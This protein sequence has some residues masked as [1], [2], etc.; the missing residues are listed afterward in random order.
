M[1]RQAEARRSVAMTLA[2]VSL[3]TP[4]TIAVLPSTSISAPRRLQFLH[5]HHAIFEDRLGDHRRAVGDGHQRHQLRLHVGGKGGI[6]RRAQRH[7][8]ELAAARNADHVACPRRSWRRPRR[9]LSSTAP[10]VSG[11]VPRNTTLPPVAMARAPGTCRFRCG[12]ASPRGWRRAA[13]HALDRNAVGAC[14]RRHA[15]P[16]HSDNRR[17]RPLRVRVR[18]SRAPSCLRRALPPSSGSRYRSR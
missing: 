18:R 3:A 17:D 4:L 13:R 9:S 6:R 1:T 15:R 8:G 12:R 2:P 10:S 5:V 14:C 11:R 7:G 16:W